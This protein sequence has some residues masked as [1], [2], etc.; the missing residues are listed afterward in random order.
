VD[1]PAIFANLDKI[2]F[3]GWNI[4]ELDSVP[5]KGRTALECGQTSKKYLESIKVSF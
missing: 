1:F 3:K 4:I 2:K 5:V